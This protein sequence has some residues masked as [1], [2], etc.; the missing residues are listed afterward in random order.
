MGAIRLAS[1][2][3]GKGKVVVLLHAFPLAGAMWQGQVSALRDRYRV[4]TPDFPGFGGSPDFD[5]TPSLEAMADAVAGL[6][7]AQNITEPVALGGL[8]MGGYAALAFARR[9]PGRLRAL[10]L[11]DTKS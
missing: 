3:E 1:G 5:G 9:H 4:L 11:A 7:D 8:S 2:D 6:L 10:I